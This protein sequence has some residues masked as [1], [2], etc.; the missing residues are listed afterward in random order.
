MK[1]VALVAVPPGVVRLI[2]PLPAPSGTVAVICVA[3]TTVNV[4]L[5]PLKL[6]ALAPEK[7][8]PLT[9]T[10]DPTAPLAGLNPVT[11]GAGGGP[12][13][14]KLA[15]LAAVPPGV[16]TLTGPLPAPAG[17]VALICVAETTE[18]L[19]ADV[20]LKATAVAPVKFVPLTV[21]AA[22]TAPLAGL[23]PVTAGAGGAPDESAVA[24]KL[25]YLN[26]CAAP[27]SSLRARTPTAPATCSA[28]VLSVVFNNHVDGSTE[29]AAHTRARITV[30]LTPWNSART[31]NNTPSA[32]ATPVFTSAA[33][34][35]PSLR[36]ARKKT[37][38]R[39]DP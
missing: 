30:G 5:V 36:C 29:P 38:P 11:V 19:A 25:S 26:V 35:E 39:P 3:E 32:A 10:D 6:T 28:P 18:K 21:T 1:L 4:A 8:V 12:I 17:T 24:W 22:P 20:P 37:V 14:V 15:A 23:N 9:V 13:T 27:V 31:H 7:F 33:I 2:G 34:L 16:V